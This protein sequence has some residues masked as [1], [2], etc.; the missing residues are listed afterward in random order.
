MKLQTDISGSGEPLVLLH[1]WGLN[2]GVWHPLLPRL[3]ER[4]R[5]ISIDLPGF[6]VN[7]D[8]QPSPY[9]LTSVGHMLADAIPDGATVLGWSLGGLLA[10][11]LAI[12]FPHKVKRLVLVASTP[13]F[14]QQQSWPGVRPAVLH[15]FERQLENDFSDTLDRFLAIQAMG[16]PSARHDIRNIRECV[17]QFPEPDPAALRHGLTLLGT[18]D[19]RHELPRITAP[20]ARFYGRLDSLVPHKAIELIESVK[21]SDY[22]HI[23][24]HASHAPFISHPDAFVEHLMA[25]CDSPVA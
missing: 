3:T 8:R 13:C 16:S 1:G 12:H 18:V 5:V 20:I 2:S 22:L 9:A 10:Q 24:E 25:A 6:G 23:F 4:Y 7:A 21:G 11:W 19:L 14:V 15:T 17:S